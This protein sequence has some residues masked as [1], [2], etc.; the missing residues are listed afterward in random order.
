MPPLR[1]PVRPHRHLPLLHPLR[2]CIIG[3]QIRF[4]SQNASASSPPT[5]NRPGSVLTDVKDS[6][7]EI[8]GDVQALAD[9]KISKKVPWE[10]WAFGGAG[11]LPYLATC[12]SA[13]Y[14]SQQA[15]VAAQWG[16]QAEI[17]EALQLLNSLTN[18][19]LSYG[20][21]LLS[22]IGALHW[23]FEFSAYG[24]RQGLRRYAAGLAPVAVAWS[25]LLLP[26]VYGLTTQ[27]A[28]FAGMWGL[29]VRATNMGWTPPWYSTYR[30]ALTLVVGSSILLTLGAQEYWDVGL[31]EGGKDLWPAKSMERYR[32]RGGV[33][34]SGDGRK[35]VKDSTEGLLRGGDGEGKGEEED[36][37]K[38]EKG[39]QE[40]DSEK[41][42]K[43]KKSKK[44][45]GSKKQENEGGND[46]SEQADV[47]SSSQ[48]DAE[49]NDD[50]GKEEG[51]RKSPNQRRIEELEKEGLDKKPESKPFRW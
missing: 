42:D 22:F 27:W 18:L 3:P 38:E 36:E 23:G 11:T 50:A 37:G 16:T 26:P 2:T 12:G 10:A 46:D 44:E 6:F 7:Q 33:P 41:K 30:F 32:A 48:E 47:E 8:K 20:A 5:G 21:I 9:L 13:V 24:G 1:L 29:D 35:V 31:G 43:L 25:S 49:E 17:E 4:Q 14:A 45:Q 15:H 51:E 19:Q 34:L 40:G 39:K 28:G